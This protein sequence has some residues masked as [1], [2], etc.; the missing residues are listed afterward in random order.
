MNKPLLSICVPTRNRSPLL[1]K[2]LENLVALP[3]FLGSDEIEVVISDNASDDNTQDVARSYVKRFPDKI[4]YFCNS[5]NVLDDNFRLAISRGKGEYL[6]LAND[7]LLF[8]DDGLKTMLETVREHL[9][10]RPLLYFR[11]FA[12][13]FASCRCKSLDELL[14]KVGVYITWIAEYGIW[15]D[16][17]A[18]IADFGRAHDLWLIQVDAQLREMARKRDA[19]VVTQLFFVLQPRPVPGGGGNSAQIFGY[20]LCQ[21]MKPY[22]ASGELSRAIYE[23]VKW[24]AFLHCVFANYISTKPGFVFRKDH[25]FKYLL[26]DFRWNWYIYAAYPF[27]VAARI[28]A[29]LR[30]LIGK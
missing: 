27:V 18:A 21:L 14:G 24:D 17:F 13:D 15:Q 3:T 26:P 4:R 29:P 28:I 22:L 11:S 19:L 30:K 7:T 9:L 20:N 8:T 6:K 5:E 1:S 23:Y 16:D 25:Y 10:D 2:M 12:G